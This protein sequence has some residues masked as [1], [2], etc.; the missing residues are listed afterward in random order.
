[1]LVLVVVSSF[2]LISLDSLV[3]GK[4][5]YLSLQSDA[6]RNILLTKFGYDV[7]GTFDFRLTHF[8]VPEPVL[9]K[10]FVCLSIRVCANSRETHFTT[11]P[12]H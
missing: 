12:G 11:I 4:I 6:R 8:I 2:L 1:M 3:Q 10:P 7:N 9:E 5:H